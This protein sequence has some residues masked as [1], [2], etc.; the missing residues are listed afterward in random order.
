MD[1]WPVRLTF[2]VPGPP[3]PKARP[4][5]SKR[6]GYTPSETCAYERLVGIHALAARQR[7]HDPWPRDARAYAVTIRIFE[8]PKARGDL[9]NYVKSL[10]DGMQSVLYGTDRRIRKLNASVDVDRERPRAEIEIE[11][12]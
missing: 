2:T 4:R 12:I 8:P 9:D 1:A 11:P 5:V 10:A 7:L 6:G 3:V